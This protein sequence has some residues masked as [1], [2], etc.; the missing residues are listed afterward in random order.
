[1]S[2]FGSSTF[3]LIIIACLTFFLATSLFYLFKFSKLVLDIQ[4][5]LE[6]SLDILDER[7]KKM[8]EISQT[9]V[10]FDSME[11]RGCIEEIKKSRD[12]ILLIANKL[13]NDFESEDLEE[14]GS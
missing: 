11:V 12:S 13:T 9:P 6:E 8:H 14:Y 7:Y 5:S 1:M 2:F 10:F 3:L 4:D